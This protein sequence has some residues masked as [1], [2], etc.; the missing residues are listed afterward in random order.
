M[1]HLHSAP[2]IAL[3]LLVFAGLALCGSAANAAGNDSDRVDAVVA[4]QPSQ[5]GTATSDVATATPDDTT[6]SG[7][8]RTCDSPAAKLKEVLV[9]GGRLPGAAGQ[10]AQDAHIYDRERIERSGQI[11]VSDFLA[12]FSEVSLSVTSTFLATSVSLL[13][14]ANAIAADA[15]ADPPNAA[16]EPR[17]AES[18]PVKPEVVITAERFACC[19]A[20]AACCGA[21]HAQ[22]CT[23]APVEIDIPSEPVS[24]ALNDFARQ[25]GLQIQVDPKDAIDKRSQAV[26]GTYLPW[27]ALERLLTDTRLKYDCQDARTI[28]VRVAHP[29]SSTMIETTGLNPATDL[30]AV[31]AA[32]SPPAGQSNPAPEDT[33]NKP[34]KLEAISVTAQKRTELLEDIP[35]AAQV[36]SARQLALANVTDLSGLNKLVPSVELNGTINGRVPLG[37]RGISSVSNE[38][39]VGIPSGVAV[40]IDGVPVP[41]DSFDANNVMGFQ[42][43]EVL[44]GP[45]STLGGRTAASGLINLTTR[46]P[47]DSP[48]AFVNT[49]ATTDGEYRLEGFLSGPIVN[50]VEG[51]LDVYGRTTPYPITNLTLDRTTTQDVYGVRAKL[52]I[53]ITDDL[54]LTL[55]GHY[56]NT[57]SRGFNFVYIYITPG[58]TFLFPGSPFTQAV[59]LPGIKP[60]WQNLDYTSPVSTAGSTYRDTDYSAIINYRLPGGYTMTSTTARMQENQHQVQDIFAVN[61]YYWTVLT[62][63]PT[64]V[65]NN[66]QQQITTVSQTSEEL[67]ILSPADQTFSWL[68][69]FFYSDTNVNEHGLRTFPAAPVNNFVAPTTDTY[70]LY[71]RST[72]NV[73]PSTSLITGLRFNHDVIRYRIDQLASPQAYHSSGSATNNTLLG[74]IA[75]KQQL[76]SDVMSYVSYSR[77]YGPAAY[78]TAAEL[79]SNGALAPVSREN[80]DSFEIGTKGSYLNRRVILNADLF[81]TIYSD[82][83]IQSYSYAPGVLSPTLTLASAGR[84]TTRGLEVWADW[85]VTPTTR[86]TFNAAYID[87]RF[88]DY[89]NAPCYGTQPTITITQPNAQPPRGLCGQLTVAGMPQGSPYQNV[90]G[91]TMPNAPKF[92]GI[93]SF[94]QRVPLA[95]HPYQWVF[96]GSY[97]YRTSAQMLPDQNPYAIQA[98]FGLLNLSAGIH[99]TDGRYSATL[100]VN[101]ITNHVYY[102]D[103]EDFFSGLWT[104]SPTHTGVAVIGQ[105]ARDARR[106]V[107]ILFSVTL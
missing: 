68:S 48:Y 1:P 89:K 54:D 99:S 102:T 86:L 52:K 90:S 88:T 61:E 29:D 27:I 45:Q 98:G 37:I 3:R 46:G 21:N 78:N 107:G 69:G 9:R 59:M 84:A 87:A 63:T 18:E 80:I 58:N 47:T 81:D 33:Q 64:T 31:G 77:G 4:Q 42:S 49:T 67:K 43:I 85:L 101:N 76:T 83:Q 7:G 25:S 72:L 74:D 35:V 8:P 5:N 30:P 105:P 38:G 32:S 82:Y 97:I 23:I 16:I 22:E 70:D 73:T 40:M 56:E 103:V 57:V 11:T 15:D 28:S 66:T 12:T 6:L 41:S 34:E 104:G 26:T 39:A 53:A 106:Y 10:S 71:G 19:F 62:G 17:T 51:S 93:L 96:D 2:A 79:T 100:F 60:S 55:M 24:E 14:A 36:V 65:F 94:E 75:V 13:C 50:G 91:D 44:L 95:N 92:K 20:L